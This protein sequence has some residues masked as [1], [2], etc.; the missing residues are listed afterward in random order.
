MTHTTEAIGP[1]EARALLGNLMPN[2]RPAKKEQVSRMAE[3]MRRKEFKPHPEPIRVDEEFGLVDGR[4]RLLALIEANV[5][6]EFNMVYG[7]YDF[8]R[9]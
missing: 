8:L 5:E 1:D 7:K 2:Y 6:L 9:E 4:Q 3:D